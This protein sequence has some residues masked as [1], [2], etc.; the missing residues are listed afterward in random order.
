MD[1]QKATC[2]ACS[3]PVFPTDDVC[4]SCGAVL[5]AQGPEPVPSAS[6]GG[7]VP[8]A[9]PL[10]AP[11]APIQKPWYHKVVESCGRLW[12][13]YPW[14]GIGLWLF[15]GVALKCPVAVQ[16]PVAI[17]AVLW[18]STFL[19]WLICDVLYFGASWWWVVVATICCYP[20]GFLAYLV[21][22]R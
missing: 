5:Q 22:G 19:F 6:P 17:I 4:M 10:P 1:A 7:P 20:I 2:P 14:I 18:Y 21:K 8:V 12:D 16:W 13:I 3:E 9:Q 15:I 11:R